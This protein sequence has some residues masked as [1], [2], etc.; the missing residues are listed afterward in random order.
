MR[1]KVFGHGRLKRPFSQVEGNLDYC[2]LGL[3]LTL[4]NYLKP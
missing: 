3:G 1:A 2:S 4:N